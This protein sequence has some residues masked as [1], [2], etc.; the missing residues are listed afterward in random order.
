MDKIKRFKKTGLLLIGTLT[1]QLVFSQE[2]Y[3]PGYVIKNNA[4]TLFGFVDYRNWEKNPDKIKFKTRIENDPITFKPTDITEFKVE[5]E[6]YVSGI[7]NTEITPTETDRLTDDPQIYI[8]V[9][10]AFLQT[11]FSGNK[12]LYY[13]KNAEGRENFYIKQ[14]TEFELL[15]YKRYLRQQDGK[16]VISENKKYLGQLTLYL[17]DC[18]TIN[19]KL[20]NT[21]YEQTSLIKLFQYYYGCSPSGIS[22]QK[23]IEKIHTEMGG[24]AG[25]SLTSLKFRSDAFPYLVYADYNS[26]YNPSVGIFLD[27][28][29]PRN[30]GKWSFYNEL[31]FTTYKVKGSYEEYEDENNYSITTTE[32]GYSYLNIN[33]LFRFKYPIGQ[34]FLILNGGISNG[35]AIGETNYKKKESKFYTINRVDEESALNS[36]RK[37]ELGFILGTGLRF[38]RFSAEIRFERGNGMSE[39]ISLNSSTKGYYFLLGY[40]F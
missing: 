4:D 5:G 30:Q 6:L 10:T 15:I 13:Y 2:N 12:S 26:S 35:Y 22:F 37:Y 7:I 17:N 9:D 3:I 1:V 19:S 40:R 38:D 33:T 11:L 39:Y 23:E 20:E 34:C 32:I 18:E 36:T 25:V 27:L 31:L 29:L 14:N 16:R 28:E 24:L 8:K 21:S